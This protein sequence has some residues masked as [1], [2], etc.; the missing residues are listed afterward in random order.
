M[1]RIESGLEIELLL[2]EERG[3][4]LNGWLF[5]VS[6]IA[7]A[8]VSGNMVTSLA[9]YI[10]VCIMNALVWLMIIGGI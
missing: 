2:E 5:L 6:S 7:L 10:L 8:I 4:D 9:E 1:V 3:V